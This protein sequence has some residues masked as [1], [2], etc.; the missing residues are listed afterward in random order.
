MRGS[1][2][3]VL[4]PG[5]V[6]ERSG[7][8]GGAHRVRRVAAIER[9][10]TAR[11]VPPSVWVLALPSNNPIATESRAESWMLHDT[12][13]VQMP[14]LPEGSLSVP[15]AAG[16]ASAIY[17]PPMPADLSSERLSCHPVITIAGSLADLL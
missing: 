11:R 1:L 14:Q 13:K 16:A 6:S 15:A 5:A 12:F 2:L 10:A 3:H 8:E 9:Q 7:D 17:D 4:E